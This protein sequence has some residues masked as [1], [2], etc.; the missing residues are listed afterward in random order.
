MKKA[1]LKGGFFRR[2]P[3][4]T[5]SRGS[6]KSAE[7]TLRA[8]SH[9][10]SQAHWWYSASLLDRRSGARVALPGME[11][12]VLNRGIRANHARFFRLELPNAADM[13]TSPIGM[14]TPVFSSVAS[15]PASN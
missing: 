4:F 2:S 7:N 11:R 10:E 14:R 6:V 8:I 9:L 12:L 5:G 15:S 13:T 3:H 1:A